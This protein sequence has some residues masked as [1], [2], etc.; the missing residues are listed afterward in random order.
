MSES[1][2][3]FTTE[4]R[5]RYAETDRMGYCYYGNFAAYFEVARVEALRSLGVSYKDLEDDGVILPVLDYE[6]KYFK[7]AYY[8]EKLRIETVI[9]SLSGARIH[10]TYKTFNEQGEQINKASTTLVFVSAESQRPMAPP[11]DIATRLFPAYNN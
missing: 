5:V 3:T 4:L 9:D 6:I 8:D 7:P 11:E 2:P 1:P 10:F